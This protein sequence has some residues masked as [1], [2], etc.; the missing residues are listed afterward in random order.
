MHWS[1]LVLYLYRTRSSHSERI[2]RKIGR[3]KVEM[4]TTDPKGAGPANGD[5]QAVTRAAQ[6]ITLFGPDSP[7]LSAA[8]AAERLNLNRTTAH[9]YF[10]T[11]ESA[12]LLERTGRGANFTPSRVLL[13][14][15]AFAVG[16]RRVIQLATSH[17]RAM[18][19]TTGLTSV[20][21]LWGAAG[22][23]V[24]HVEEDASHGTIVTVRVGSQLPL[25]TAQALVFLAFLRDQLAA[26]RLMGTLP[27]DER[28][29]VR[30]RTDHIRQNGM[31]DPLVNLRGIS[32]VA[33]PVFDESGICATLA[34]VGT[35]HL[36]PE[37]GSRHASQILRTTAAAVSTEMGGQTT[38][39]PTPV[40]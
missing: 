6:I 17:M 29:R 13:Q 4:A 26:D 34:L 33:A 20:L 31:T 7:E 10:A 15:G 27:A 32:V 8:T 12:G 38:N 28:M 1:A 16:R 40:E 18:T 35:D 5:I 14:I 21:S 36:L 19:Q 22:P 24:S 30:E 2:G 23:V 25:D 39:P 3:K 11:M 9:R 37:Q